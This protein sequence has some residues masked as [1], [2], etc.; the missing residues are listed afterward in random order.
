MTVSRASLKH[1]P[2]TDP[3]GRLPYITH[4]G[5]RIR[6]K[7]LSSLPTFKDPDADL[8]TSQRAESL[9][10]KAYIN[11]QLSDLVVG[12]CNSPGALADRTQNYVLYSLPPNYPNV[13]GRAQ[14]S[15]LPFPISQYLPLRLRSIHRSRLQHVG[16]WG[17]GGI[18]AADAEAEDQKRLDET[19]VTGP[20]G[21]QALRAWS[22]WRAGRV[23]D[24]NRKRLGQDEVSG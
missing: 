10:W 11:G 22:G 3:T 18:N 19:F 2:A 24:E 15:G 12:A 1:F 23:L 21:T 5:N 16:L 17:L 7:H 20:G 4:L 8:T 13:V 14:L 6:L 9:S